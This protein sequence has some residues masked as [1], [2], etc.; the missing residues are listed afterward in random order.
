[1]PGALAISQMAAWGHKM[2]DGLWRCCQL[3]LNKFFDPSTPSMKEGDDG[4]KQRERRGGAGGK[5]MALP[6][7]CPNADYWN[8]D[9]SCQLCNSQQLEYWSRS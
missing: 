5:I 4:E 6:V 1:M 3:L 8:A 7:D 2:A 9:H